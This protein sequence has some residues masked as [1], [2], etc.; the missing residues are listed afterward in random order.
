M[1]NIIGKRYWFFLISGILL[2]AGIVSLLVFG[3]Q[4]SIEFSSGTI[5]TVGFQNKVTQAELSS[6]LS[7]LGYSNFLIQTTS[8]GNY[9]VRMQ[10]PATRAELDAAARTALQTKLVEKFG[11]ANVGPDFDSVSPLVAAETTR[12]AT[13]ATLVAAVGILLYISWA[14]RKMPNPFRWGTSAIIALFHDIVLVIGLFSLFGKILGWEIDLMFVTGVLAV[15][16]FSNNNIVVIYDRIRE[17]LLLGKSGDDFEKIV[18]N[19]VVETLARSLNTNIAA[20]FPVV[21]LLIVVGATIQNLLIVLLVGIVVGTYDSV[22]VA[23]AILVVWQKGE[24]GR[25]IGRKA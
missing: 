4:P 6:E 8:E 7:T 24:W 11:T 10:D 19:S 14:F 16:G 9:V 1:M 22:C 15:L 12:N 23:P 2:V 21:A 17:N 20:L 18:N 3:L 13:I 5:M 25:F